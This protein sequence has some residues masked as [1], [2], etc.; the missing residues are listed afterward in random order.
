MTPART[1]GASDGVARHLEQQDLHPEVQKPEQESP[2]HSM[3]RGSAKQQPRVRFA[4]FR[5]EA[6]KEQREDQ[7]EEQRAEGRPFSP[8]P[9]EAGTS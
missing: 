6:G 7:S 8:E 5:P 1:D 2:V 9:H 4:F 3:N